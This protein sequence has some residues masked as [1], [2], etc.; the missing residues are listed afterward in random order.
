M[1][2][3][4][5]INQ[6]KKWFGELSHVDDFNAMI[7]STYNYDEGV[8]NRVV[9]L[10]EV[11]HTGFVFYTNYASLKGR[12]IDANN[13]VAL[14]FFWPAFQRQVRI[15]GVA[16]KVPKEKSDIYFNQR[17]R[18]SQIAAWISLQSEIITK[19]EDFEKKCTVMELKFKNK[20][21]PRPD[22]WGGYEVVPYSVE[23]W[24]GRANRM[25]DRFLY[26]KKDNKWI[27]N[28]L[29]P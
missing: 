2:S 4:S 25:H 17:P 26:Q 28:R 3:L 9:L 19:R 1:L 21:I 18:E 8:N 20:K 27:V 15:N 12:Q 23:F 14:C 24:Q 10:K 11:T 5:P 16:I 6:F 29:A 13:K 22:F 7:L